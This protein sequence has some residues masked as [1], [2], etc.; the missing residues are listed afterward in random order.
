[1]SDPSEPSDHELTEAER[2]VRAAI[3]Q[4][5]SALTMRVLLES[6][7]SEVLAFVHDRISGS[8]DADEVFADFTENLWTSLA[9]YRGDCSGRTWCY[10]IARRAI[11]R[12]RRGQR[13][14]REHG[15]PSDF[16][17][18]SA[19]IADVRSRTAPFMRTEVKSRARALRDTL[20]E[21]DQQLLLLRIERNLAFR[22]IAQILNDAE[23]ARLD[24]AA[25]TRE[26]ARLRK[27][28]QHA[29]ERLAELLIQ[30]GL[31]E[32]PE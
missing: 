13:A 18:H 5:D 28:F 3:A 31:V 30:D 17:R 27:R 10:V 21:E 16:D 14:R 11:S 9:R 20:P 12:Y 26:A 32:D 1:M 2:R 22:D 24:D 25:L 29:K 8:G 6:Y 23:D 15:L 19:L 4:G 7:G